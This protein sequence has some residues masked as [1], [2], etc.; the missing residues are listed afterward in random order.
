MTLKQALNIICESEYC[1]KIHDETG[2]I[3]QGDT[4]HYEDIK[5]SYTND[6]ECYGGSFS[7]AAEMRS[8]I[9]KTKHKVKWITYNK[10]IKMIQIDVEILT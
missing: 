8:K 1:I 2:T 9:L 5:I 10:A 4:L 3:L 7:E 6:N